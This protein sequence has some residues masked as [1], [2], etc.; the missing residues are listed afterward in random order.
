MQDVHLCFQQWRMGSGVVRGRHLTGTCRHALVCAGPTGG[1]AVQ[2]GDEVSL[3]G[4][5][6][7][8]GPAPVCSREQLLSWGSALRRPLRA[9][10]DRV[11]ARGTS[12]G[13]CYLKLPTWMEREASGLW[14]WPGVSALEK[15]S[16]L[17]TQRASR[18]RETEQ[19]AAPSHGHGVA[20]A[21]RRERGAGQEGATPLVWPV[22]VSR[23]D[24]GS[25]HWGM[26]AWVSA[27]AP[28]IWRP[29]A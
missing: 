5:R 10:S 17:R 20:Q 18:L 22:R 12:A 2:H 29:G 21:R 14:G 26:D 24:S 28:E 3:P 19:S 8:S 4:L 6:R 7:R 25:G 23:G 15:M 9:S 11:G 16:P 1:C 27:H 13:R